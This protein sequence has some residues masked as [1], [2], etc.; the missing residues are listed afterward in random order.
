MELKM[1]C[2]G[3]GNIEI[4]DNST[5]QDEVYSLRTVEYDLD[6]IIELFEEEEE[7]LSLEPEENKD[8]DIERVHPGQLSLFDS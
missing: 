2:L 3:I 7:K 8:D 1:M 5:I 6:E 4:N